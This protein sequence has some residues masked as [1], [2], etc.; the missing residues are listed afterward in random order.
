MLRGLKYYTSN[1]TAIVTVADDGGGSGGFKRR[2][3]NAASRGYKKLYI[4]IG[5]YRASNGRVT[6]NI[7]FLMGD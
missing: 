4:S 1:I 5:G 2:P 3:R 7:D 6:F